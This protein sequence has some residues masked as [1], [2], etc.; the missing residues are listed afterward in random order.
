MIPTPAAGNNFGSA[1]AVS[2]D[3]LAVGS[4]EETDVEA[5]QGAVRVYVR[6]GSTWVLQ[7]RL[8][9]LDPHEYG[10]MGTALAL[11]GD[12]LVAGATGVPGATGDHAGA[13]YRF[14]RESGVWTQAERVQ[15][16]DGGPG[17]R[18][19]VSVALSSGLLLAG[20]DYRLE[21]LSRVRT[22]AAYAFSPR[23]RPPR[24][25]WRSRRATTATAWA[26][27]ES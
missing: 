27:V 25:T 12:T 9:P 19:G 10:R 5:R 4:D 16:A 2:G 17:D 8:T 23:P 3:T 11:S 22:G 1:V 18:L 20:A 7:Q 14:T 6:G 26:A 24:P 21:P 13:A 15:A